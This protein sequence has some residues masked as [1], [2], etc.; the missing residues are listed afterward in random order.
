MSEPVHLIEVMSGRM[1]PRHRRFH[2]AFEQ[3][4][5]EVR[6]RYQPSL[7][8]RHQRLMMLLATKLHGIRTL[9]LDEPAGFGLLHQA[10][11]HGS[12]PYVAE[13][14]V[15]LGVHGYNIRAHRRASAAARRLMERPQLRALLTFSDWARR[16]FALHF[17]PELGAKCRTV[18]PLAFEGAYCGSFDHRRYDFAFISTGFRIK[19]GPEVVRAFCHTR[20]QLKIDAR[21]CVVTRLAQAHRLLGELD[22]YEGVEWREATLTEQEIANLLA[23]VRCL[24]HPSLSDSFGVVVLEALAAGC[25]VIATDIAS[26]PELVG[27][28]NGWLIRAPTASVVGDSFVTEFGTVEYHEGYLNT[29]S[30]HE[31]ETVLKERIAAF[32]EDKERSQGMMEASCALYETKFSLQAWKSR[33]LQVLSEAFPELGPWSA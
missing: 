5:R 2:R 21:L 25:A 1:R 11:N 30:L 33:M 24:L 28:D 20:K 14:D 6:I 23:D 19:A 10:L 29:L 17:G 22:R 31:L 13:F 32:L 18:Y 26:F 15:P 4:C 7:V 3:L 16:S 12:M 27:P 9:R 8:T